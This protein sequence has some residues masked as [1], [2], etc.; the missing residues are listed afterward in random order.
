MTTSGPAV[1]V[2]NLPG[3]ARTL[4][5]AGL[6]VMGD[7]FADTKSTI[8]LLR[9]I[10]KGGAPFVIIAAIDDPTLRSWAT[11]HASMGAPV[12]IARSEMFIRGDNIPATRIIDLPC[13]VNEIM[14]NFGATLDVQYGDVE[15]GADGRVVSDML[16][17]QQTGDPFNVFG[18]FAPPQPSQSPPIVPSPS[19][20][21]VFV[22][23][24][25]PPPVPAVETTDTND[26]VFATNATPHITPVAPLTDDT[27]T[28]DDDV[29][30]TSVL[31]AEPELPPPTPARAPGLVATTGEPEPELVKP[32]T[33]EPN[34]DDVEIKSETPTP[35]TQYADRLDAVNAGSEDDDFPETERILAETP[36]SEVA[37]YMIESFEGM[38][39]TD[40]VLD[41][42]LVTEAD[43]VEDVSELPTP[44]P[45]P[46]RIFAPPPTPL[47]GPEP[48]APIVP[49]PSTRRVDISESMF[50]RTRPSAP[51]NERRA[52]VVC[53][54]AGKGGVGKSTSMI[55]LAERA[56]TIVP[57]LRVI[58]VDANRGQGDM[59]T[60]L[61]LDDAGLPS[62][63]DAAVS[64]NPDVFRDVLVNPKRLSATRVDRTPL[65][66][67]IILSPEKDQSNPSVVTSQVYA[68]AIE[69]ARTKA[70]LVLIDTQIIE[71]FD[72]SGLIDDVI[73]PLLL[74]G[75]WGLGL[76]D[77]STPGVQNLMWVLNNFVE[78]GVSTSRLMVALNKVAPD[79]LID[80]DAMAK[81][82][83]RYATWMGVATSDP[84]I[85][86]TLN[87]GEIPG[88][89]GVGVTPEFTAL[90]DRVL[91]HVTGLSAFA[92]VAT[93]PP[94]RGQ[95]K[96][97][98]RFGWR[99]R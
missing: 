78:R 62:I 15:I 51:T 38:T 88:S 64:H 26:D 48:E 17:P 73:V 2:L 16:Q 94:D 68:R 33:V 46:A 41:V 6:N 58:A 63:Y 65:H 69:Y 90:L 72:T 10:Q 14:K 4:A 43:V 52:K 25:T 36:D 30:L 56:A 5:K 22:V 77:S 61:K 27:L 19:D 47:R 21:D 44:T 93:P 67:G 71:S 37:A 50:T 7:G 95:A 12:L 9:T 39:P 1:A 59:R 92:S 31:E 76:S 57:G 3:L 96:T 40:D 97:P 34:I 54:F 81:Y 11:L 79:S 49:A 74:D 66:V 29:D 18:D 70:D 8:E 42:E 98:R 53:V 85:E 80:A 60:F 89:S 24:P 32:H 83:E 28:P 99:R 20:D 84:L 82:V 35:S 13:T 23:P 91:Y 45:E 86:R 75:A 87:L 55:S